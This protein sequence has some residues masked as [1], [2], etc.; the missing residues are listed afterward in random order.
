MEE[1][2][3]D[4]VFVLLGDCLEFDII[5]LKVGRKDCV[6]FGIIVKLENP[7][8]VATPGRIS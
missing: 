1:L 6:E 7:V 4:R 5:E 2:A 3:P 8:I